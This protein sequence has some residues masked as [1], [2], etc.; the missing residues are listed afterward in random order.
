[1]ARSH[2]MYSQ[3]FKF[4]QSP[5]SIPPKPSAIYL[6]VR[7]REIIAG[8]LNSIGVGGSRQIALNRLQ[9]LCGTGNTAGMAGGLIVLTGEAGSGKTTLCQCL[10]DQLPENVDVA[11][12][13]NPCLDAQELL[14]NICNELH[15][16][17][18]ADLLNEKQLM[19]QLNHHLLDGHA[20]G[21]RTVVLIEHAQNLSYCALQQIRL[22]TLLETDG[23]KLLQIILVG[24]PGLQSL[25]E[26]QTLL[27][28]SQCITARYQLAPL[29]FS[30]TVA[31]IRQHI[32]ASGGK[33]DLFSTLAIFRIYRL[34]GGNPRLINRICDRALL[35]T[36]KHGKTQVDF[37]IVCAV[38][39]QRTQPRLWSYLPRP[40][41]VAAS[42]MVG[43]L[44]GACMVYLGWLPYREWDLLAKPMAASMGAPKLESGPQAIV[45]A[46]PSPFVEP[47]PRNNE[48]VAQASADIE[49]EGPRITG[50]VDEALSIPQHPNAGTAGVSAAEAAADSM[51]FKF[52]IDP[53]RTQ[54]SAFANLFALW[55]LDLPPESKDECLFARLN[56]LRC[57]AVKEN[58][59]RLRS[60]DRPAVLEFVLPDGG[61]RYAALVH[62]GNDRVELNSGNRNQSFSLEEM[63]SYWEGNA[64]LL[65]KPPNNSAK[66][67]NS[68]DEADNVRWLR[69]QLHGKATPDKEG[70][71]D[72]NLRSR[73][74]N[75]QYAHGLAPDGM[76]GAYTMILL[77][78]KIKDPKVPRLGLASN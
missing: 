38:A 18:P 31:Y 9:Q 5:F 49:A 66:A 39:A 7:C 40:L 62:F 12:I 57:L 23:Q 10:L 3:Y 14:A 25:L 45:A 51:F 67:L 46:Q 32:T 42:L 56:G 30:D 22:L 73:L 60:L 27:E 26:R 35:R 13:L 43:T 37:A 71:F 55:K 17:P 33:A 24:K 15:V 34:A 11:L 64:V 41:V 65:W 4:R 72:A 75:F 52:L 16:A 74:L 58:W 29:T 21:R 28:V 69:E 8:I 76:A 1:M 59:P 48:R 20:R 36:Y 63:L 2:S 50:A 61:K 44:L 19:E 70:Y 6:S 54:K 78:N 68:G 77:E 47:L 53:S